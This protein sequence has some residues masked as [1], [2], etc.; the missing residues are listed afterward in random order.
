MAT[1]KRASYRDEVYWGLPIP[2]FGDREAR[3]VVLGLAAV[4]EFAAAAFLWLKWAGVAYLIHLG[5]AA[6]RQGVGKLQ[7]TRARRKPPGVL[8]RQGLL[9]AVINPKTLIF[10]AAFLPQFVSPQAGAGGLMLAA[11][12]YLG[13]IFTGDM[14]WTATAQSARPALLR[15]GRIRHRLTG[16]LFIGAGI[17]LAL[18]R[19]ER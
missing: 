8:F 19:V 16:G 13:V 9:L 6:W 15:L 11:G 10:N 5:V 4:L 17:G 3:I 1:E 7:Q 18:S 14:I 2:G 12:V